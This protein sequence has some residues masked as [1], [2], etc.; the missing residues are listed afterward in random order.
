ML[1]AIA[2]PVFTKTL[3]KSR[4]AASISNIRAAY[5]QAQAAV[6]SNAYAQD[7]HDAITDGHVSIPT[8]FDFGKMSG[9]VTV[10]DVDIESQD[11]NDWSDLLPSD[12]KE[13][14]LEFPADVGKTGGKTRSVTFTY[15]TDTDGVTSIKAAFGGGD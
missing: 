5:A 3:E 12:L 15:S 10:S 6:L 4:D 11:N 2:I 7:G 8:A 14:D 1:T 9:V 13:G